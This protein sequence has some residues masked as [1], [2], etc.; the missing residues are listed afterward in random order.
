MRGSTTPSS[1]SGRTGEESCLDEGSLLEFSTERHKPECQERRL[2][3]VRD[4]SFPHPLL[5]EE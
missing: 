2:A 1:A 5:R 3:G 4:R